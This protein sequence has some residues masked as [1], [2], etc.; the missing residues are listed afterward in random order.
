MVDEQPR[1]RAARREA[2]QRGVAAAG[3][4]GGIAEERAGIPQQPRHG[5]R[6]HRPLQ[7]CRRRI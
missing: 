6:T 5:A 7:G 1:P 4:S 2:R 3:E